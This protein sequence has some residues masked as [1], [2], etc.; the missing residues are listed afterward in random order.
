MVSAA[1]PNTP[2]ASAT[3]HLGQLAGFNGMR[4][5]AAV[6]VL[7]YHSLWRTPALRPLAPVLGHGDIGVEIFFVMS[8]FLV[9]RP[10]VMHAVNGGKPVAFGEFWRKRIAR[11]WP[12]YLVALAGAVA[13][14]VGEIDGL[15]GLVK[16]G[17]LM[18]TEFRDRG[19]TGLKV[20]WTLVVEVAFYAVLLPLGAL[21]AKA[22]HRSHD[23]WVALCLGLFAFGSVAVVL[24]S[25]GP[26]AIPLR[27]L[28]PYLTSFA[29]GML[30]AGAEV[31]TGPG[32]WCEP[33]LGGV[34]RLAAKPALCFGLAA[35]TFVVMTALMPANTTTP[36]VEL[37]LERTVQCFVQVVVA[38]LALTP[39]ALK[40]TSA[41]WLE[42]P[43]L[44]ALGS[45]SFGFYLWHIQVL[46]LLRPMLQGSDLAAYVGVAIAIVGAYLLGEGSRR[47]IE[48]PARKILTGRSRR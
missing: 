4:A 42:H 21:V 20:S 33:I 39:L 24:T 34:R 25:Y 31:E 19:G 48:E 10:L 35:G 40:T 37:G 44:V 38:F 1:T 2:P 45:A 36:A 43:A 41:P 47:I 17:L 3:A 11:I 6:G 26:T 15:A 29:A 14:G 13:V 27:V 8:G 22:R 5:I 30:L 7:L 28:P 9:A 12:A 18:Q 16:H 32:T 23:A 46:R